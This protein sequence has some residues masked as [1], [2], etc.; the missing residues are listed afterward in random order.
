[1]TPS[2]TALAFALAGV[3]AVSGCDERTDGTGARSGRVEIGQPAPAYAT[4]SLDGDSVSLSGERGNVV[5]LNIWA[6]W[7]HPCRAE[8]PVLRALHE[9]YRAKG[10]TLV[11]VS[12]DTDG[13]DETIRGFMSEFQMTFPIWRDPDERISSLFLTL[14]VPATF[15]IDRQGILRWKTIGPISPTDTSLTASIERALGPVPLTP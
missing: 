11:G 3:V 6:T 9:Q 13:T 15:L 2:R 12:V 7:C 10:L 5:L 1:M 14:G 4:L 8:I